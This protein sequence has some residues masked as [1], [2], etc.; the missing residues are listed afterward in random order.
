MV[1]AKLYSLVLLFTIITPDPW[2]SASAIGVNHKS[3]QAHS[4]ITKSI[5]ARCKVPVMWW[6]WENGGD[7]RPEFR[8][9]LPYMLD[10]LQVGS[11]PS[12]AQYQSQTMSRWNQ[13]EADRM[14]RRQPHP[15]EASD[16]SQYV[17]A[18]QVCRYRSLVVLD[19]SLSLIQ[20]TREISS[21]VD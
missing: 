18:V 20:T 7:A 14:G 6:F 2:F 9:G 3:S 10:R 15:Q 4:N 1:V 16:L 19:E 21:C 11:R 13:A 8:L 12:Q 5:D 17:A